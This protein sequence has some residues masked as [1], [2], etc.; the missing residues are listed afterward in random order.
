L[1]TAASIAV[2]STPEFHVDRNQILDS[3][4]FRV[5]MNSSN[6]SGYIMFRQVQHSKI[7]LSS[8][9]FNHVFCTYLKTNNAYVP[10]QH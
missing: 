10:T 6:P 4:H 2:P 9:D 8:T 3:K 1:L 7:L 5:I